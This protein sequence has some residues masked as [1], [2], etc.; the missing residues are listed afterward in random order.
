MIA[1]LQNQLVEHL[2]NNGINAKE[3]QL[4]EDLRKIGVSN[5]KVYVHFV[6]S[7]STNALQGTISFIVYIVGKTLSTSQKENILDMVDK[8][9]KTLNLAQIE[10]KYID[11]E[12]IQIK[13]VSY[14]ETNDATFTYGVRVDIQTSF[15][16]G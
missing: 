15:Y 8:V 5:I 12:G 13:G 3:L 4:K 7:E 10:N 9:R 11:L 16:K 14:I 1:K 6:G 2:V